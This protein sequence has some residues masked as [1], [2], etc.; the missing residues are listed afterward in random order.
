MNS[1]AS[2]KFDDKIFSSYS[3]EI[4]KPTKVPKELYDLEK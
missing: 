3:K 2:N 4:Q 1:E